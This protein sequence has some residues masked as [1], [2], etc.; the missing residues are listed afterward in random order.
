[1]ADNRDFVNAF[2]NE[3]GAPVYVE[4]KKLSETASQTAV[5]ATDSILLKGT[6]G[7]YHSIEKASFMSAVKEALGSLIKND[8][9]SGSSISSVSTL[10]S[11]GNIGSTTVSDL[12]SVLGVAHKYGVTNTSI[13]RPSFSIPSTA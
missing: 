1:M 5:T 13:S 10:T 6:D 8:T 4:D 11:G 9:V 12:A 7:S 2:Q 3:G